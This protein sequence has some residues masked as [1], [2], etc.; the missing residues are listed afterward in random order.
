MSVEID[1]GSSNCVVVGL[2]GKSDEELVLGA[3]CEGD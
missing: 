1:V 3:S 2:E